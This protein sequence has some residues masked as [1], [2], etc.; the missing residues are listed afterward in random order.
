MLDPD[1]IHFF[2][3]AD[4]EREDLQ[5]GSFGRIAVEFA[6]VAFIIWMIIQAHPDGWLD[7]GLP[8]EH[9]GPVTSGIWG[10]VAAALLADAIV[11]LRYRRARRDLFPRRMSAEDAARWRATSSVE[12]RGFS[13]IPPGIRPRG[14]GSGELPEGWAGPIDPDPARPRIPNQRI[15]PPA[16]GGLGVSQPMPE[17]LPPPLWAPQPRHSGRAPT[18]GQPPPPAAAPGWDTPYETHWPKP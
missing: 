2:P 4:R 13:D 12:T 7:S 3:D 17:A 18:Q 5:R 6:G 11:N 10:L 16:N 9:F 1:D 14:W 8:L 15:V